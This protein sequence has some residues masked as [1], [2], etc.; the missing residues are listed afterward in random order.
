[1]QESKNITKKSSLHKLCVHQSFI[2]SNGMTEIRVGPRSSVRGHQNKARGPWHFYSS[3]A[4]NLYFHRWQLP[5]CSSVCL[6]GMVVYC[7]HMMHSSMDL[8]LWLDSP[9][10]WAPWHQSMSHLLPAVFFQFHLEERWGMDVQ[11]RC[12]ILRTVKERG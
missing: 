6:T 11:T 10:F 1:M 5:Q 12:N 2:W 4:P 9:M 7:D 8:S 3:W